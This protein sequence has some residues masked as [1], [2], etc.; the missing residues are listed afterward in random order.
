L[1]QFNDRE[2]MK[3]LS[4]HE[5]FYLS[6]V[7]GSQVLGI[8]DK[9]GNFKPGKDFDALVI[10]PLVPDCGFKV[11]D[12]ESPSDTLEKFLYRGDD[13][14]IRTVYVKGVP[15]VERLAVPLSFGAQASGGSSPRL[16][17]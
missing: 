16:L 9:V 10:D 4:F 6:T 15:V 8:E 12:S 11:Y 7:G 3:P 2:I 13:R 5:A 17:G 14:N 1:P